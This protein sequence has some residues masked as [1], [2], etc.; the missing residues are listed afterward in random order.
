MEWIKVTTQEE[1]NKQVAK[2][3]ARTCIKNGYVH[4]YIPNANEYEEEL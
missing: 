2:G 3:R 1:L 4:S